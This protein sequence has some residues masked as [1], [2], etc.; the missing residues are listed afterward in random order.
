MH[1]FK[2]NFKLLPALRWLF[3]ILSIGFVLSM[4]LSKPAHADDLT[5]AEHKN[6][7]GMSDGWD[8]KAAAGVDTVVI[9]SKPAAAWC[10]QSGSAC[11][12]TGRAKVQIDG[13][14][15]SELARGQQFEIALRCK[16]KPGSA[17][18]D[19]QWAEKAESK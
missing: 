7:L 13:S 8:C 14:A 19:C 12:A 6:F 9:H 17:L 11:K 10:N 16:T 1:K 4:L 18:A 5:C 2:F 3:F 15:F